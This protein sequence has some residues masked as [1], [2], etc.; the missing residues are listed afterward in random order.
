MTDYSLRVCPLCGG[1]AEVYVTD[2]LGR[3]YRHVGTV[4]FE[5]SIMTHYLV[6]CKKCG[7][8][9]KAYATKNGAKNRW[10]RRI[11]DKW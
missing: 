9:T 2:K 6:R 1:E 10:N 5:N 3:F 8:R 11:D 4:L 7:T